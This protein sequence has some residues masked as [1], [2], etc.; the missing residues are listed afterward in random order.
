MNGGSSSQRI[1]C[2]GAAAAV[3]IRTGVQSTKSTHSRDEKEESV[4]DIN[5][6]QQPISLACPRINA[7]SV[8]ISS[9]DLLYLA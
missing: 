3:H 6:T 1:V 4:L 8:L 2:T 7:V 9:L 5:G